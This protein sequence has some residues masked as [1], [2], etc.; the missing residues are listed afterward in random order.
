MNFVNKA[1]FLAIFSSFSIFSQG[2]APVPH[3]AEGGKSIL[4][5]SILN[6]PSTQKE[7]TPFPSIQQNSMTGTLNLNPE[8]TVMIIT[9]FNYPYSGTVALQPSQLA[10]ND[11]S[12]FPTIAEN[13]RYNIDDQL[14]FS[15][16]KNKDLYINYIKEKISGH[17]NV[18]HLYTGH[19][20][21][22]NSYAKVIVPKTYTKTPNQMFDLSMGGMLLPHSKECEIKLQT[23][24]NTAN[25][26]DFA[27]PNEK[28]ALAARYQQQS[29]DIH[30]NQCSFDQKAVPYTL[31]ANALRGKGVIMFND[32]CYSGAIKKSFNAVLKESYIIVTSTGRRHTANSIEASSV[33]G[34]SPTYPFKDSNRHIYFA[35]TPFMSELMTR[36]HSSVACILDRDKDR[37]LTV[38]ELLY[39]FPRF[40]SYGGQLI[41]QISSRSPYD[42]V[43]RR[44]IIAHNVNRITGTKPSQMKPFERSF[45]LFLDG[46]STPTIEISDSKH[47]LKN[48]IVKR[49]TVTQCPL[50]QGE[51]YQQKYDFGVNGEGFKPYSITEALKSRDLDYFENQTSLFERTENISF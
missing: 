51:N 7:N 44:S 49:L 41:N 43:A 21:A 35:A 29:I 26:Y 1:I 33:D 42:L 27:T 46:V 40:V 28:A 34:F 50:Y 5:K 17:K 3:T 10:F 18:V 45:D 4:Q 37:Y 12:F 32:S 25:L 48:F 39:D 9:N 6:S 22:E 19:G 24:A 13:D 11:P 38:S 30:T 23:I 20:I 36:T 2:P 15:K 31:V 8:K 14:A 47:N 16:F